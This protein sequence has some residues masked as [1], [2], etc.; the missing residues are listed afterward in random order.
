MTNAEKKQFA[1]T[2]YLA[3][4]LNRKQIAQQVKIAEK[5]LRN[6]IEEGQWEENKAI[7]GVT[8]QQLL[9]DAYSQLKAINEIIRTEHNGIPTKDLSD[10]KA[11]IRKE[12]EAFSNNP[13]HVYIEVFEEFLQ[14]ASKVYPKD[15]KRINVLQMEF[16]E[17]TS[18]RK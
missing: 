14:W 1:K 6:W 17:E 16:L 13:L 18:K 9:Q 4:Q 5:T 11:V 8:R 2:L 7:M 3:G 15:I 12:I 10:A